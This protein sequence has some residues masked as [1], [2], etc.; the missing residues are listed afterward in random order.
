MSQ[1]RTH[2]RHTRNSRPQAV[3][4]SMRPGMAVPRR[5]TNDRRDKFRVQT[6]A[7]QIGGIMNSNESTTSSAK[8]TTMAQDRTSSKRISPSG[9]AVLAAM[10]AVGSV[11]CGITSTAQACPRPPDE[12]LNS[13][14]PNAISDWCSSSSSFPEALCGHVGAAPLMLAA[15]LLTARIVGSG[16]FARKNRNH[17]FKKPNG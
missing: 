17:R 4:S 8:G 9:R 5:P 15:G 2:R 11:F 16:S 14:D 6:A 3:E 13:P 1:G 10:I 7:M 12:I